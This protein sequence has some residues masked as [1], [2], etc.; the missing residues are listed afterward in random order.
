MEFEFDEK[1]SDGNKQKHG[2]NFYEAQILFFDNNA[3]QL[4]TLTVDEERRYLLI[5]MLENKHWSLIFTIR[6]LE[7]GE[8]F[9]NKIRIISAR[10]SRQKERDLYEKNKTDSTRIG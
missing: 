9:T 8:G 2:L 4:K 7:S 3:L 1:K 10:R 5:A 6:E